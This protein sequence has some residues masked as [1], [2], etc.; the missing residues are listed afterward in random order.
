MDKQQ[1]K[2]KTFINYFVMKNIK[3]A[4]GYIE[5]FTEEYQTL[6]LFNSEGKKFYSSTLPTV[7]A[8]KVLEKYKNITLKK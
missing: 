2:Q 3:F 8:W 6:T 4:F 7:E 5:P 1:R